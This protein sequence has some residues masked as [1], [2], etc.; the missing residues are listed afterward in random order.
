MSK[1]ISEIDS[2]INEF[3]I[4]TKVT[5]KFSNS[6]E[7]P[8]ELKIY[9]IKVEG[10]IFS[11]FNCQIGDSIK[12]KS[13]V[14]K[15]EKAEKKYT[16]SIAS[17]NAAIFVAQDP[18]DEDRIIINMGNIPAKTDVIFISEFIQSIQTSQSYEFEIFRNLPI[19]Q[20]KD[21]EIFRNSELSGRIDI[22]TKAE[23]INIK[24]D[25]LMKD[26]KIIEEKYQNETK[27]EYLINY[28]IDELPTF[29]WY[30]SL[31][32]IP[33]SKIYFDINTNE[34]LALVQNSSIE[35]KETNYFIQ[36]KYQKE[37]LNKENEI[38]N[39][40]ALFIFLVD[41]SG[42]MYNS[43]KIAIK[44]L[45]VFMQSLPVGSYYQIIGF[46]SSFVKYD[47]EPKEYN[48]ENIKEGLKIIE[49]LN[50]DLG[51]TN[52]YDPLKD[53][54]NSSEIYD[55]I[56]LPKNIFLLTDGEVENKRET[57]AL[58]EK[59]NL[60]FTI[61]SIGIG[62]SF[63]E[64]LIK[65]AGII[66]K[67]NYNFCKNLDNLNSIIASEINAAT[68][69]YITNLKINTSLGDKNIIK[70]GYTPKVLRNNEIVK[71]YYINDE[72]NDKK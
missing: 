65:N 59:N 49:K 68:M 57:L 45:H 21:N 19:F 62:S 58:I 8:L 33:S 14:I 42:S 47:K 31:D 46:G 41:E 52:I 4:K 69:P 9:V 3:F 10:I 17:G 55:K 53:I 54:Y 50:S 23:L 67:G 40:P 22:K 1:V 37:N 12:V 36:Y 56:D 60:K 27:N 39:K 20:G 25:I 34:P 2:K 66:G 72:N 18:D 48:K 6:T 35:P 15:K 43:I 24:K 63:D 71:L 70:N 13:K 26:L 32:Y 29:S 51:G 61:Y 28:K 64:D 30:K 5:Q 38:V 16:D 44:A 7:N 11:S